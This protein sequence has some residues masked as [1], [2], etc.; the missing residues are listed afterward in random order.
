VSI[1]SIIRSL[2]PSAPSRGGYEY[3]GIPAID[4]TPGPW[5][6]PS[7][8]EAKKRGFKFFGEDNDLEQLH[9]SLRL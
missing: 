9:R 4:A 1:D 8:R 6:S 5:D 2:M 7:K 3:Q